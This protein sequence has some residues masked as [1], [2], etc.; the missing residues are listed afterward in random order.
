MRAAALGAL[1]GLVACQLPEPVATSAAPEPKTMADLAVPEGFA[2]DG[3]AVQELTVRVATPAGE[4]YPEAKVRLLDARGSAV[5]TRP[6]DASGTVR[7]RVAGTGGMR[8]SVEAIGIPLDTLNVPQGV[9]ELRVPEAFAAAATPASG[10]AAGTTRASGFAARAESW[11]VPATSGSGLP[12]GLDVSRRADITASFLS[13]VNYAFPE[14]SRVQDRHPEYI[15][16]GSAEEILLADSAEVWVTFLHEGAGYRNTFGYY[17]IPPG[18]SVSTAAKLD[19]RVIFPNASLSG[20]G[21]GLV[22][23]DRIRLGNFRAGSRIGFLVIAD[24]W[25]GTRVD[26]VGKPTYYSRSTLNPE[27]DPELR[28]HVAMLWH[29]GTDRV[30]MGFEDLN[31]G[32]AG[33]DHDFNDVLFTVSWN[34]FRAVDTAQ[35]VP[36]PGRT[37]LDG[38]GVSD[39]LD[40]FPDDPTRAYV[41]WFPSR[42]GWGTLA[43]EDQWPSDG[44][45]DFNDLTSRYRIRETRDARLAVRDVEFEIVPLTAGAE[46]H[47]GLAVSLGN[48]GVRADSARVTVGRIRREGLL[49]R[50]A[51]TGESV[52]R[53]HRDVLSLFHDPQGRMVNTLPS[54]GTYGADTIRARVVFPASVDLAEPPYAPFL[55]RTADST[56]EIHLPDR[57]ATKT[58]RRNRLGT[59]DD[60]SDTVRSVWF[61]NRSSLPWA[62]TLPGTWVP[63]REGVSLLQAYPSFAG[64]VQSAGRSEL[65]WHL[66]PASA[67]LLAP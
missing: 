65:D 43:F 47:S 38:D 7:F 11:T 60:R 27:T 64:W 15:Q 13:D 1:L 63:P 67:S 55:Y 29:A 10:S 36:L 51:A 39:N 18:G 12:A 24:G 4:P 46:L 66:R 6:T 21:G 3:L 59:K 40:E 23:G 33:C 31:R 22:A 45:Y 5:E 14:R 26:T 37:D 61:R 32:T 56:L 30:V 19:K 28:K 52:L 58:F 42:D 35:F 34:P 62:L 9:T 54:R 8:V 25:N 17:L 16:Q 50:D 57:K 20:S 2:F 48:L 44:D 41:R 49:S 53:L